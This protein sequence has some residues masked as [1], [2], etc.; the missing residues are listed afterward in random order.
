MR[1][2][3]MVNGHLLTPCDVRTGSAFVK[4]QRAM[5]LVER[6]P[7]TGEGYQFASAEHDLLLQI[8]FHDLCLGSADNLQSPIIRCDQGYL[9]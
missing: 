6:R 1:A 9:G 5:A 8:G 2:G 7:C 4:G 3:V